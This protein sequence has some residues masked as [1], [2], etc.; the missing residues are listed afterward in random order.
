[1]KKILSK[2]QTLHQINKPNT[3]SIM[4]NYFQS[5]HLQGFTIKKSILVSPA[6]VETIEVPDEYKKVTDRRLSKAGGDP[7]WVEVL[8]PS[9]VNK[10][11]IQTIQ[12]QL[13]RKG[14]P[15]TIDGIWGAA[16]KRALEQF[17]RRNGLASGNL[18]LQT[19]QALY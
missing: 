19:L 14:Y 16:T 9:K 10:T 6:K 4:G 15:L 17:Q 2:G 18:N 8:C 7:I 12:T 1:M 5:K 13:N 3:I 11:L